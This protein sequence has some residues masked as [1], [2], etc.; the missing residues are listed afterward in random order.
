[1]EWVWGSLDIH[2]EFHHFRQMALNV[3]IGMDARNYKDIKL[4]GSMQFPREPLTIL[5][6]V[7]YQMNADR[8]IA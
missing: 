3:H 1:M 6:P 8:P 2:I 7:L 4:W 5:Y